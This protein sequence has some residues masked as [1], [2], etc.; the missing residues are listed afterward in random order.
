[1]SSD[2]EIVGPLLA[3]GLDPALRRALGQPP[4]YR[5]L[6]TALSPDEL[7]RMMRAHRVAL[8]PNPH[9]EDRPPTESAGPASEGA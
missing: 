8:I 2:E 1:V 7:T 6:S 5:R 4:P 3:R 9:R